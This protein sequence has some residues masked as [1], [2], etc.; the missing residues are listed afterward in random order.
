MS[1]LHVPLS[2]PEARTI[3][4]PV[5]RDQT[6]GVSATSLAVSERLQHLLL[7]TPTFAGE[8]APSQSLEERLYDGLASFKIRT[9]LVAMHLDREWRSRLFAQLDGLLAA[10][11]WQLD[12]LP[13]SLDSFSTFL[14]LLVF[15]RPARRPGLGATADGKIIASWTEGDDRLTVECLSKDIVRWNLAVTIAG[16]RERAAAETPVARLKEVLHPYCP[17]RWFLNGNHLPS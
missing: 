7:P 9:S 15:I 10:E 1:A 6:V 14:R 8:R 13:P 11:D 3:G 2:R 5:I 4:V 16:E 12:D 17:E